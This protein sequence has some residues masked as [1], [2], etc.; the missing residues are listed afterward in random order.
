MEEMI[1]G[2]DCKCWGIVKQNKIRI[3]LVCYK[4][5]GYRFFIEKGNPIDGIGANDVIPTS[6]W[7]L[8]NDSTF[9]DKGESTYYLDSK[10]LKLN[11]DT[12]ERLRIYPDA[13]FRDTL[14][15]VPESLI[16][17]I[18]KYNQGDIIDKI[19]NTYYIE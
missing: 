8:V 14:L 19:Y 16:Y 1:A 15:S 9:R 7:E 13:V 4:R 18:D 2:K 5:N 6:Y 11:K 17:L 3:P 10:I 12:F